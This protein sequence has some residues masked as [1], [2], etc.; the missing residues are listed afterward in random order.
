[1]VAV[2]VGSAVALAANGASAKDDDKDAKKEKSFTFAVIGDIPYGVAQIGEFPSRLGELNAD[3]DVQLVNHLGDIKSGSS[4][5]SDEYF[6]WVKQQFDEVADPLVYTPGDNEWTDC[7]RANNGGYDPLERL[8][9]IRSLFFPVPGR[10]LGQHPMNVQSQ[11]GEGY[12]ENVSYTRAGVA[13]AVPHVVGSNDSLAPWTGKTSPTPE[14]VNEVLGRTAADVELIRDTF[15]RA[16]GDHDRA[17]VI[18]TQADMF[19]VT[20]P[21]PSYADVYGFESIVKV[22]AHEAASFDGPVYLF[23]GDSHVANTDTPL[24]AGS[25]WLALYH[26]S[27]PVPNLRR[28]TIEGSTSDDE[29]SKVTVVPGKDVLDIRRVTF[30]T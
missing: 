24:A 18:L 19:D 7:H 13:F 16:R 11:A 17:V 27:S 29:W 6:S 28:T 25:K 4:L 12:V 22:I 9:A 2:L 14:Q 15:D 5:C 1:L 20:I 10:T 30:R 21:T 3:P 8:G 23:N 26:L